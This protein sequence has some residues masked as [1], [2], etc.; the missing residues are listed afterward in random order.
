MD[1]VL[2]DENVKIVVRVTILFYLYCGEYNHHPTYLI[3]DI[4][5][6]SLP[7]KFEFPFSVVLHNY[8]Q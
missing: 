8:V 4:C 7:D 3:D 1:E 2:F 6:L 5:N